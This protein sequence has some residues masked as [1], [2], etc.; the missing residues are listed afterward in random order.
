MCIRDSFHAETYNRPALALDLVEEFRAP[1]VDSLV[2][3]VVKQRILGEKDFMPDKESGGIVL[4]DRGLRDFLLQFSKKLESERL[5]R[6]VGRR[7]S[8]RKL[9]EVQARRL[10]RVISGEDEGYRAFKAR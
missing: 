2:L 9:F 8:Y 3:W 5:V 1:V 6:D 10:A 4:S 7:L